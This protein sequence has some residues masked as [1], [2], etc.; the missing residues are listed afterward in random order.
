MERKTLLAIRIRGGINVSR[1]DE[2][3]LRM[4]R[5]DR[6]N[7]ATL[8][9]DRPDYEGMLRRAKD[10][11]TWG[12]PSIDTIK[13]LLE[14]RGKTVGD[15]HITKDALRDLGYESFDALA[16]ALKKGRVEFRK[17]EVIKPFF[18]LRPP[19]KGYK[20]SVKRPFKSNGELGY[21]GSDIDELAKRM[22]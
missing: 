15:H 4:L 18:R 9:D 5:I 12:E 10:F 3:N 22:C 13:M 6:N 17:L 21:R 16:E 2:D 7:M 14:K 8:L 1:K 20:K 19:R 11:I